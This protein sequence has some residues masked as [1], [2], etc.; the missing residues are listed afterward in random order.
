[1]TGL[2]GLRARIRRL[3]AERPAAVRRFIVVAG[4]EEELNRAAMTAALPGEVTVI[5]T[6]VPHAERRPPTVW[7]MAGDGR[8]FLLD[9]QDLAA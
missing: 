1:M 6:G 7:E 8:W 3:E 9:P 4:V 5:L 2:F